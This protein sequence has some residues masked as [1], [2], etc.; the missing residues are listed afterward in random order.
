[1]RPSA[2]T[3]SIGFHAAA[4]SALLWRGAYPPAPEFHA[5]PPS[6][7]IALFVPAPRVHDAGGGQRDPLPV[8]KGRL[9]PRVPQVLAPPQI[10]VFERP[11]RLPVQLALLS[12][13][14]QIVPD[15]PLDR[16]GHPLGIDGMVSGGRGG[17]G[18]LGDGCC[19]G[20]GDGTGPGVQTKMPPLRGSAAQ[21]RPSRLPNLIYKVEPEYS[22]EARK[23]KVQGTVMLT[24]IVD[25]S[26]RLREIRV[27]APL[28]LGLDEKAVAAAEL[29]RFQPAMADGKPVAY[30]V[31]IE[32]NFRLL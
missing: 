7:V 12:A 16:I 32:V 13:P 18:G 20:I 22:E 15:L 29:W 14:D 21:R 10:R 4:L 6:C 1:M 5:N 25:P 2:A 19:D 23:A 26:G 17:P 11:A 31:H 24:A 30:P 27:I 28:G 9:P 3:V 8:S